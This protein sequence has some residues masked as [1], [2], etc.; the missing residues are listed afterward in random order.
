MP[1]AVS[2][3]EMIANVLYERLLTLVNNSTYTNNVIEVVRPTRNGNYTPQDMQIVLTQGPSSRVEDLDCPGN[4]PAVAKQQIFNIRCH[5]LNDEAS[6]EAID[7]RL[8][9]IASDVVQAVSLPGSTWHNFDGN[10]IDAAWQ[11]TESVNADGGIDGINVPIAIIY[12][13]DEN[14]PY[15]V[16]A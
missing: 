12:R 13:T 3:L 2:V 15:N 8:N 6:T 16:R 1:I 11:D 9:S 14:S 4:P 7:S 10:A 5:V